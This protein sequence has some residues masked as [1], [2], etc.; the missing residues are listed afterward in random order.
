MNKQFKNPFRKPGLPGFG[1]EYTET[2]DAQGRLE[3]VRTFNTN[4][5]RAVIAMPNVQKT[6]KLAAERRLR[7]LERERK[8]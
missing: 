3:E 1:L 6:V 8:K 2:V 5:L 7:K 4:Q